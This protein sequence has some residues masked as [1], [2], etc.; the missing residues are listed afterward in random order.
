MLANF[1]RSR[2]NP[3]ITILFR[4]P[5]FLCARPFFCLMIQC[6]CAYSMSDINRRRPRRC[7]RAGERAPQWLIHSAIHSRQYLTSIFYFFARKSIERSFRYE[8]RRQK[9]GCR[10][11]RKKQSQSIAITRD[12]IRRMEID[13]CSLL[14]AANE[15]PSAGASA[16]KR[17]L[18]NTVK[19][20]R[21]LR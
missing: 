18:C 11:P 14:L 5:V 6:L 12:H 9:R 2:F 1:Y 17:G 15:C 19:R 4:Q 20:A 16:E 8:P 3:R 21:C 7:R 10:V 13:F